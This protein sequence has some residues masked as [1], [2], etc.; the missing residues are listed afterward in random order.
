MDT[1]I[2]LLKKATCVLGIL[3]IM[4]GLL[5]VP[6]LTRIGN[7]YAAGE[8]CG[9]NSQC[10]DNEVC[11]DHT[12]TALNCPA[13]QHA[14]NHACVDDPP[15]PEPVDG[16]WSAWSACSADCG[17]GTQTRTCTNPAPA[18]GGADCEGPDTQACNT[19]PCE[20]A[21]DGGWSAW[22]ACSAPC[23]GGTQTRTCTNPAPANGG[24]DCVGS[25]T[26]DCNT[27]PCVVECIPTG[28][29]CSDDDECCSGNYCAGN[30]KCKERDD[31]QCKGLNMPCGGANICCPGLV[32]G[33]VPGSENEKCIP[34]PVIV[35][36]VGN[37]GSCEGPC[38]ST[39][40]QTYT[41]TTPAQ[42]GGAACAFADGATRTCDTDPCPID[43]VGDWGVCEGPCGSTG[44]QTFTITTSAQYGG[45]ACQYDDGTTRDCQTD[46]CPIDCVGDWT[47]CEGPCGTTSTQT[48]VITTPAQYGGAA[49]MF[50]ENETRP[51]Q[52]D[53]C[54][55][56]C[57]GEWGLCEGDCGTTGTQIFTITTP[58]DPGGTAC[59]A[60]DGAERPCQTD[61]CPIDCVGGWDQCA[62]PCGTTGTQTYAITT[63]AQ[64]GGAT[65]RFNDGATRDCQTP[66]CPPD[67]DDDTGAGGGVAAVIPV[68]AA[69]DELLVI[70]VTGLALGFD[71]LALKQAFLFAGMLLFGTSLLLEGTSRKIRI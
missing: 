22:S 56:D 60:E 26:R 40:T 37:W 13:G 33:T 7:I 39:G 8:H 50:D 61:P 30:G 51:C 44:T 71:Y 38:G 16:G 48:F 5:P 25:D 42:N 24:A 9:N 49:C 2:K 27:Q 43:C 34:A 20:V 14:E 57:I 70:P 63:P 46:P 12:C 32:C 47:L 18:N 62:G 58:A 4:L 10:A 52:T 28:G 6:M 55:G 23:G 1:K 53:P 36:C 17:G 64:Y 69:T 21:I 59:E 68:T 15:P 3:F 35:D 54:P 19:Q 66:A 31:D 45:A 65:C 67:D 29:S 11:S 41:I